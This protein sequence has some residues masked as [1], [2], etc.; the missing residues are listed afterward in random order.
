MDGTRAEPACQIVIVDL[1]H[2]PAREGRAEDNPKGSARRARQRR[3]RPAL[4]GQLLHQ[5]PLESRLSLPPIDLTVAAER[6]RCLIVDDEPRLRQVL[7]RLMEGD[8]F[9]CSEA[10]NGRQALEQLRRETVPL[11]LTDL[12]MPEMDGVELLRQIRARHPDIAVVLITAIADV[13]TAVGCLGIGAMDYLTKPFHLDEVRARVSQALEKRRLILEN[14]QYQ[15][16]L[17]ERV[18][19]QARR[20]EE[21]FLASIQSLADALEVKDPYTRGH[22]VRVSQ[23]ASVVART[24]GLDSEFVRQVELGGHVHDIGKIGV[25]ESVLNKAGTLTD[26]EYQHVMSHPLVGW[27]ILAPL[28]RDAPRALAIVRSHHERIDGRG[29]PDGLAGDAIPL[30]ARIVAVA[31]AFDAMTSGRPYRSAGLPVVDALTELR[32]YRGTQFE[33]SVVDVFIATVEG[34]GIEVVQTRPTISVL[35]GKAG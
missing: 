2:A 16:R 3:P 23:Y 34:G 4:S 9:A 35:K 19:V 20:L 18:A 6:T 17:E 1:G 24:M 33:P 8:G 14:R 22:S 32:H 15:E 12:R 28:L 31:D 29:V 13:E 27:R 5:S 7:V 10:A 11:V 26:E 25:R 30:E 21:L